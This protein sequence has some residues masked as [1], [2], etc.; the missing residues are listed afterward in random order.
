[1]EEE[2]ELA[3]VSVIIPVY[4]MAE[5][6]E[7]TIQSVLAST[8]PST[9]VI[10][11]NDGS[12][13]GSLDICERYSRQYSHISCFS[14]PNRGVSAARNLAISHAKGPYI[15]PLDGDDLLHPTYLVEAVDVLERQPDVKVVC[16]EDMYIGLK[17]KPWRTAKYSR[18]LLARKNMISISSLYRK[19]DWERVGGYSEDIPIREDWTFWIAI[20][21]DTGEVVRLPH[22]G[23]YYR[24][25]NNSKRITDRN[26]QRSVIERLNKLHPA[27][28]Q[29]EL[30][31]P[32]RYR[33]SWSKFINRI[34]NWVN[35]QQVA[36]FPAYKDLMDFMLMLPLLFKEG[37]CIYKGR[38][39]IRSF[40][41][42]GY[43]LV[44]KSY[45]VPSFINR[46]VYGFLRKSK[47]ERSYLYA[48][49]LRE[50]GFGTPHE[51]GFL[52]RRRWFLFKDS[53]LVTLQSRL[54]YCFNDLNKQTFARQ[55]EIFETIAAFA[56]DMHE[57]E[58]Y[59]KDFSGGNILFD[60][61]EE[62][63]PIEIIDINRM[64]FGPV[65]L[66]KGC[67]NFERLPASDPMIEV[68]AHTYAAK[69][70]FD[71]EVCLQKIKV[72]IA[73]EIEARKK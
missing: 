43:S 31:G 17:N 22:I 35:Y 41:G 10:L 47:A 16:S 8:Y 32:L 64:E 2:K 45:K 40:Q 12:T 73:K 61:K 66:D 49:R 3:L 57:Q 15:F 67:R 1:M 25:R 11:V 30:Q 38:N 18:R 69:R 53:Y 13:D 20:L 51:V 72:Y 21:K 63:I 29:R 59:H 14:Q 52:T 46:I 5:Y 24:I 7:E 48:A 44:V 26:S 60:D 65:D 9:E 19:S 50:K 70:G 4:N 62:K 55:R 6:L 71:P 54:P 34:N 42:K 39:E 58:L 23:I 33:R 56:A 36:L 68:M 28:F 27:F 37:K